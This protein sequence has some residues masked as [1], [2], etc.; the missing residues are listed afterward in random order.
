MDVRNGGLRSSFDLHTHGPVYDISRQGADLYVAGLFDSVRSGTARVARPGIAKFSR[1]EAG[2]V[3]LE[4][5]FQPPTFLANRRIYSVLGLGD[6]VLIDAY[7]SVFLDR[8]TAARLPDAADGY[9]GAVDAAVP[10]PD[11]IVYSATIYLRLAGN[12][13]YPLS[14]I[15]RGD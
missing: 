9:A 15:S 11:G 3:E 7:G 12:V 4:R 2:S 10:D 14:F 6:S 5:R 8:D 1:N 13:Y